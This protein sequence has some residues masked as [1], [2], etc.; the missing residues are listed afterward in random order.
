[1][2]SDDYLAAAFP[3][4]EM[5]AVRQRI[6]PVAVDRPP[7]AFAPDR[8]PRTSSNIPLYL[9]KHAILC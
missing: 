4:S 9:L 6:I 8:R 5:G 3:P 1:M 2:V 7:V